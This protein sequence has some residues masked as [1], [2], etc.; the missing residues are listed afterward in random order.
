MCP[1]KDNTT[2]TVKKKWKHLTEI[3]RYKIEGYKKAGLG[4]RKIAGRP[5]RATAPLT[6]RSGA[7]LWRK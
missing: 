6:M 5:K 1:D 3:D 7:V 2:E 4:N